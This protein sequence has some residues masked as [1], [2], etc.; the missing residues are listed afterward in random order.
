ME[1]QLWFHQSQLLSIRHKTQR[2]REP[3][4]CGLIVPHDV[5]P[6][7]SCGHQ[8]S[9]MLTSIKQL[10][11][12]LEAVSTMLESGV[13]QQS[14]ELKRREPCCG[15]RFKDFNDLQLSKP[16]PKT[17]IMPANQHRCV[18]LTLERT[19]GLRAPTLSPI[20]NPSRYTWNEQNAVHQLYFN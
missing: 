8:R 7:T 13:W 20:K 3:W 5:G 4:A 12:Y 9:P 18:Q 15:G 16:L 10:Y 19:Q 17:Q 11:W 14:E 2:T 1:K 6:R